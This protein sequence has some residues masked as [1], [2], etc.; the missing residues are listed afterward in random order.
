MNQDHE[1]GYHQ[2]FDDWKR[3][4]KE[5]E[6]GDQQHR[7]NNTACKG[8]GYPPMMDQIQFRSEK[9]DQV[10]DIRQPCRNNAK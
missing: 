9:C 6:D 1:K 8:M 2:S 5:T 10:I 4:Y 3:F 7:K